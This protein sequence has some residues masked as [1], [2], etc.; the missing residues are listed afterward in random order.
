MIDLHQHPMVCPD[1][2]DEFVEYL[3]VGDYRWGYE[4][5]KHGGWSAVATANAF[6]G[7]VGSP[8][9]LAYRL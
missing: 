1:N 2:M 5:I 9:T 6:R 7:M 3:R 4:A 8:G